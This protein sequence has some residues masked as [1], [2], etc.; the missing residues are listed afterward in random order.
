MTEKHKTADKPT[1]LTNIKSFFKNQDP[2][3]SDFQCAT[4]EAAFSY[5]SV[6]HDFSFN[7]TDCTSKLIKKM[8]DPKFSAGKTK[9][10][11]I[12]VNV[13]SPHIFDKVLEGLSKS[14]YVS[15]I[16]DASNKK[17]IK[18]VPI[19]IRYFLPSEGVKTKLLHFEEVPG[20]TSEILK[21]LAL[22]VLKKYKLEKKVVCFAADN[23]NTNFGG[24]GS[25]NVY[26]KLESELD[27]QLI[28]VGCSV[29]IVSFIMLCRQIPMCYRLMLKSWL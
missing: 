3:Q 7:A 27:R 19:I 23:T 4:R 22:S 9:T 6:I 26:R 17:D 16:I 28:A 21:D 13:L 20:E 1:Q 12:A 2:D 15:I 18:V 14:R 8:Y 5:H 29:H 25:I 11:A 10:E 24:V